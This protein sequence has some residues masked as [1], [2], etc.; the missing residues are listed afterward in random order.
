M[1]IRRATT[2][3]DANSI[4]DLVSKLAEFEHLEG[5]DDAARQRLIEHIN[6]Q[7]APPFEAYLAENAD[8]AAVGYVLFFT[9][10]STFLCRP[11]IYIEDIF[12]LPEY[13]SQ[14]IGKA[15]LTFCFDLAKERGCGR[16]EWTVLDWNV[17]AQEFYQSLGAK[18]HSEWQHY[19]LLVDEYQS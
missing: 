5:P 13:R 17:V 9:T 2:T 4:V 14:G 10:Y 11:S 8:A 18:H 3:E 16:V 19:R 7:P 12:V 1:H 6:Q 15:L